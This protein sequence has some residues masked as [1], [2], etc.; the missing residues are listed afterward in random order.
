MLS[1]QTATSSSIFS[2]PFHIPSDDPEGLGSY[3]S[4]QGP[5]A[6]PHTSP[7]AKVRRQIAAVLTFVEPKNSANVPLP[8]PFNPEIVTVDFLP[9]EQLISKRSSSLPRTACD[10]SNPAAFDAVFESIASFDPL[11]A[12]IP[13]V[14]DDIFQDCKPKRKLRH[15]NSRATIACTGQSVQG[16]TRASSTVPLLD[17]D[18]STRSATPTIERPATATGD[19][20]DYPPGGSRQP[21]A[22]GCRC[23]CGCAKCQFANT[24][25]CRCACSCKNCRCNNRKKSNKFMRILEAHRMARRRRDDYEDDSERD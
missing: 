9:D 11:I 7:A 23:P 10:E 13:F 20:E 17:D 24:N 15:F 22:R 6:K 16:S 5:P 4:C 1:T 8:D 19:N 21:G 14:E 3:T 18:T 25:L 12:N 2:S